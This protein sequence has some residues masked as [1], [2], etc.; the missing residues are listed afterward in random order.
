VKLLE[1]TND[2]TALGLRLVLAAVMF[3]HG[4]QHA[5]GWFGG[6]GYAGTHRWMTTTVGA[7]SLLA[8]M[9]I[10]GELVAPLL[11]VVGLGGRAA[12]AV[13]AAIL[14]VAATTHLSN[15]FFM[16]WFGTQG[17]EG[18][19]YHVLGVAIATAIMVKGSGALT[20]D[21]PLARGLARRR[22][23]FGMARSNCD[24]GASA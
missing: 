4:A 22:L 6:Y 2:R 11:L 19:E 8:S 21:G 23:G 12:A 10:I 18:F 1:T 3:P 24:G 7:P 14:T 20:L 16:N 17:G 15:G 5:L 13:L 9:A